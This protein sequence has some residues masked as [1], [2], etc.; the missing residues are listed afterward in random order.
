MTAKVDHC[1]GAVL[2]WRGRGEL[3]AVA[4][5]SPG[6]YAL[7]RNLASILD[8]IAEHDVTLGRRS[9]VRNFDL[10]KKLRRE[11]MLGFSISVGG[12]G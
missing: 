3:C 8:P 12:R 2:G 6:Y 7:K 9:G 1:L 11:E 5:P 4:L 10:L